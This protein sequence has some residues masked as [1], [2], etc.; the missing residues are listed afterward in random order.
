MAWEESGIS[1]WFWQDDFD[2]SALSYPQFLDFFFDRP[3]VGDAK[4]YDLF[5]GG[6]D[7][8][9]A[10]NPATV[11]AHVRAMCQGFSEIAKVYSDEELN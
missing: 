1:G 4:E 6:I 7:E 8:F 11:V 10:S 3:V 5:G 2:L 9:V